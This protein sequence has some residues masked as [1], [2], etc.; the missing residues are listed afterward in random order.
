MASQQLQNIGLALQGFGA[1][2]QGN[3]PQFQQVQNQRIQQE[4]EQARLQ[5]EQMQKMVAERQ[6]TMFTDA[7]AALRL[8]ESGNL[9]GVVQL[10]INR[11]QGLQQLSQMFPDIDPSDT[12]RL[13]QLAVA[14]RNGEEEAEELLRAEL[15]STVEVGKALGIIEA[16]KGVSDI[17]KLQ[18]DL[19]AGLI[20]PEQYAA[21]TAKEG[22]E[23]ISPEEAAQLGLP[24]DKQF[25]RN[26]ETNQI[27]QIGSGPAVQVN[28][29]QATEGER[30]AGILA[31]RLDF[32][33]SQ[34]NDILAAAPESASPNALPTVFS[35]M[36]LDYLARVSNPSERQ[37]IE[38]AQDDMLDA[39]LTLGTGAA[40]T[41]EQFQA[42]KRSYFPQL[43]DDQKTI[44]AKAR[45]LTNLLDAAYQKAGRGAPDAR[46]S[47]PARAPAVGDVVEG[48]K[49]LG[50]DPADPASWEKQ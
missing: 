19:N 37:I 21:E 31:N 11:L 35:S 32:A 13:T 20:S 10:G 50:G 45:R 17:G 23:I 15:E 34:I 43:G 22:F 25:Q 5:Q 3:L 48:Y 47:A 40:Y 4:Q 30:T 24:T 38:A 2:L 26:K 46:R 9:D 18:Q 42:Y 49:F 6:K 27:S 36:G 8:L 12:Q 33:Q 41:R 29:G 39:A 44:D 28:T 14:A 7:N 16:P 1:G